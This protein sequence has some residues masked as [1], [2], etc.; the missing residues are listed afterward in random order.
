[1][2]QPLADRDGISLS[3]TSSTSSP[4]RA[5][6][7][8]SLTTLLVCSHY[9]LGFILGTAEQS[10]LVG[11][12]GSLYAVSLSIGFLALLL[13]ARFYWQ[14]VD[15]IWTLLGNQYGNLVKTAIALMSWV[16]LI[17]IAA[18]QMISAAAIFSVFGFAGQL[19]IAGL[20]IALCLLSLVPV[21][22]A[23]QVF[24]GLLLFNV[25]TLLYALWRLRG[26]S[27]LGLA[28]L[29][30]FPDLRQVDWCHELG[31]SVATIL[32]VMVDMKC[33]QFIVQAKTVRV[34]YWGCVLAAIVLFGLAFLPTTVVL[35]SQHQNI[36]PENLPNKQVLPYILSRVGGGVNHWQGCLFILSLAVPAL[37]IGSN[38]FR[39]QTKTLLDLEIAP[40]IPYRRVCLTILNV[41]F[42]LSIALRGGE[43]VGLIVNFYA[44]YVSSVWIP[45]GAYLLMQSSI[46]TFSQRS[47]QSALLVSA[48]ASIATLGITLLNPQTILFNSSELTIL[49]IGMGTGCTTLLFTHLLIQK[50]TVRRASSS[51]EGETAS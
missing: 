18:V 6:G 22:R 37:G 9:G 34:A 51:Q 5:L 1:M 40:H 43:I 12:S 27:Q 47:V 33:Q 16:S 7:I 20:A 14:S 28:P 31:I 39:I 35:V 3:S 42:A 44:T 32:I 36:I 4:K 24:R 15:Q 41:L 46:Y 49:L 29:Q 50:F 38:I 2:S 10:V 17:G 21:E 8:L 30:F 25:G 11:T 48:I 23:S 13:L 19:T 26:L 45:L